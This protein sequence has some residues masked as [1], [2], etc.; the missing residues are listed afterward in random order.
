MRKTEAQKLAIKIVNLFREVEAA[1]CADRTHAFYEAVQI[2]DRDSL[3][4]ASTYA[5]HCHALAKQH[6][7]DDM[8]ESSSNT[9]P[10]N[11]EA[12]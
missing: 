1:S 2:L 9:K 3:D 4:T 10:S 6:W 8:T 7:L 12:L 5:D 11:G